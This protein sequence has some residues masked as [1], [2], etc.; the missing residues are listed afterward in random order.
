MKIAFYKAEFGLNWDRFVALITNGIYSHCEL[1]FS[2]GACWSSSPRDGGTRYKTI[3]ISD[4]WDCVDIHGDEINESIIRSWCNK[5]IGIK[6]DW[7]GAMGVGLHLPFQERHRMFCVEACISPLNESFL[8]I[9]LNPTMS[10]NK[11][12]KLISKR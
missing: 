4:H 3:E 5:H 11:F 12:H 6:Y 10:P 9:T 8:S 2:D 1:V 7:I